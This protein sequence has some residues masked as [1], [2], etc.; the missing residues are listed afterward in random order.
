MALLA[1]AAALAAW[2]RAARAE[3]V[4][5]TTFAV[6][7]SEE[8]VLLSFNANFELPRSVEDALV[9]GVP[10]YFE[11]QA[12]LLQ[13]RWYWRDKRVASAVRTWRVTYQPLTRMYRV[14]SGGLYQNFETLAEALDVLR[15]ASRWKIADPAQL[16]EDTGYYV[17]FS[18]RLDTSQL[19][20]PMQ[21]GIGGEASWALSAERS[22]PLN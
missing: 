7:R 16:E 14:G 12:N 4:E 22:V 20:R 6:A 17:E 11:A 21:I 18:F 9:R 15:R 8:G 13:S 19:P 3:S 1:L 10:L 2:P 5:L